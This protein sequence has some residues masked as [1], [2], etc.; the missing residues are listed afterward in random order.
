MKHYLC[1]LIEHC[2]DVSGEGPRCPCAKCAS[3]RC[4]C[5]FCI[6]RRFRF[7]SI[8]VP[9]VALCTSIRADVSFMYIISMFTRVNL[10]FCPV[11]SD[12]MGRCLSLCVM[13]TRTRPVCSDAV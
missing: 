10:T 4:Q 8:E 2:C 3:L 9:P 5:N 1:M 12:V 6:E 11:S 13:C 7:L